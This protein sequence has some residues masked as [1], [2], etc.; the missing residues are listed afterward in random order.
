MKSNLTGVT[1]IRNG[2]LLKYPWELCIRSMV[3]YCDQVLVNCDPGNDDTLSTLYQLQKYYPNTIRVFQSKWDMSNTGDGSELAKQVNLLLP[4]VET[5]WVIYLQADELIHDLDHQVIVDSIKNARSDVTQIELYRTYFYQ[6]L[7]TRLSKEELFLGRV[8]R[9]GTHEIG[10]DGMY[11]VRK[12][13]NVLRTG[14][15]I[16]HYSRMGSEEDIDRRVKNLD[17][18]FHD[19]EKVKDFPVFKYQPEGLSE[20]HGSH[21]EGIWEFYRGKNE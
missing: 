11:L 14:T 12:E 8:F 4:K 2:N 6:S 13:G 10:G 5:D 20:Y 17:I 16:Y 19:P 18:L 7:T 3:K 15:N 21:P 1:L 9:K